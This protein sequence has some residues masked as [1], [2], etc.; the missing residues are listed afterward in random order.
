[1]KPARVLFLYPNERGMSTV[2]PSIALLSQVLKDAG[3]VTSL[4]D[5][6][7]YKFDD[8]IAIA[9]VDSKRAKSLSVR[10]VRDVDDDDLHFKKTTRSAVEDFQAAVSSFQPDFVAVS[11]TE[12]TFFRALKL[13]RS[14]RNL[15]I[16]VIFGGVFPTFAPHLVI[17]HEEVDMLCVGEG[18]NTIVDLANRLASGQDYGDVTNLW[19]RMKESTGEVLS[20]NC[21]CAQHECVGGCVALLVHTRLHALVAQLAAGPACTSRPA[22]RVG[23]ARSAGRR[24][25]LT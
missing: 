6:T 16:P 21:A 4:F 11:C 8:E 19:V 3:H 18:E 14:I 1:M 25:H 7:F 23:A 9:D 10:P 12:T 17:K 2:P 5:T 13:I 20:S 15:K 22:V 24:S